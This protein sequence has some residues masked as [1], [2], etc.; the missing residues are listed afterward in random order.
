MSAFDYLPD[1][2]PNPPEYYEHGYEDACRKLKSRGFKIDGRMIYPPR[3]GGSDADDELVDWLVA[4]HE[5]EFEGTDELPK[6]QGNA[7][8]STHS[9]TGVTSPGE[10]RANAGG[11]SDGR[12]TGLQVAPSS[13]ELNPRSRCNTR[14]QALRTTIG[15]EAG[16]RGFDSLPPAPFFALTAGRATQPYRERV[17]SVSRLVRSLPRVPSSARHDSS[18]QFFTDEAG[19]GSNPGVGRIPGSSITPTKDNGCNSRARD[20]VSLK[21][22]RRVAGPS[23]SVVEFLTLVIMGRAA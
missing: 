23:T 18:G 1:L 13:Y 19:E 5:F 20:G 12:D 3:F 21:I 4:E 15:T 14:S 22:G 10:Q 17:L 16:P 11:P 6:G 8:E 9:A 2:D 7:A